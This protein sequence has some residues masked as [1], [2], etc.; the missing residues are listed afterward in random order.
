MIKK[1]SSQHLFWLGFVVALAAFLVG[2]D[3]VQNDSSDV[4]SA[5]LKSRDKQ[6][7]LV[8]DGDH[9]VGAPVS[10]LS[11]ITFQ[12]TQGDGTPVANEVVF[13]A[14]VGAVSTPSPLVAVTDNQG[15]VSTV[16]QTGT[17][18]GEGQLVASS[19]S[20]DPVRAHYRIR[21]D[22][23]YLLVQE[24]IPQFRL[25]DALMPV[26]RVQAQDRYGNPIAGID[27]HF[28]TA[29]QTIALSQ[30]DAVTD[31]NG[32]AA[33]TLSARPTLAG[34]YRV[35]ASLSQFP[36]VSP[37]NA[38]IPI[39]PGQPYTTRFALSDA[40]THNICTGVFRL[41]QNTTGNNPLVVEVLDRLG[42]PVAD[43][44]VNFSF[45]GSIAIVAPSSDITDAFGRASVVLTTSG[46]SGSA[47]TVRAQA[48]SGQMGVCAL[49]LQ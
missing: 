8:V 33:I 25:D 15:N 1:R 35:N 21:P 19:I 22:A 18:A 7:L 44:N 26:W 17:M 39:E 40:Y 27:V 32:F 3:A 2:C 31:I 48:A 6:Q 36:S 38:L 24:A 20:A 30:L 42:N 23:P 28:V 37:L 12:L 4:A 5:L 11:P 16:V 46:P 41:P 43:A 45:T 49:Q 34:I 13:F 29:S 10:S 9:Q 14:S 47:G